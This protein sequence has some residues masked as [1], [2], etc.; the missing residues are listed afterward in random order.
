M[1]IQNIRNISQEAKMLIRQRAVLCVIDQKKTW[2]EVTEI[3]GI[4]RS[5]LAK[6]LKNY[7]LYGD[8]GIGIKNK[9]GRPAKTISKLQPYQ[10][11]NIVRI[12]TDNNPHQLKF[13]FALWDRKAVQIL[14]KQKL[15]I[16]LSIWTVGRY[17]KKWGFTPQRPLA[18]S[19]EKDPK[20]V[21]KF[22]KEEF[23]R[24]KQRAKDENGEIHFLDEMGLKNNIHHYLRGYSKKGKTPIITK[25]G[26]RLSVN[27]ISTIAN[28]G[29]MRFMTYEGSMDRDK[30]ILFI[31]QL[32]KANHKYGNKKKIFLIADNLKVHHAKKVQ[33]FIEKNKDKIEIFFLPPYS[34]DLN[35][36]E[37]LNQDV[38]TNA[39]KGKIVK[40]NTELK[41]HLKSYLFKIQKTPQ[42]VK[43]YF[44]KE[45]V[46][47]AL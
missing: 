14:I 12:I 31:K 46:K 8:A 35:P 23:P 17:L 9:I 38:K 25:S 42:K 19:F 5:S 2:E 27:M 16:D 36:D 26:K 34:P 28:N 3:F 10:C 1:K 21:A 13:P 22:L 37:L 15:N 47:Y 30:F 4:G 24:I 40:T 18:K 7:R 32:I 33:E 44:K 29:K 39:L 45:C 6:W 43:N 11:A 41:Y 20:R